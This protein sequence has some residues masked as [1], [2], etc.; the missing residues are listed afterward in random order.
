LTC[1]GT[2]VR[3]GPY[4]KAQAIIKYLLAYTPRPVSQ[5][6]LMDWLW[7]ESNL[8]R[9]R[10][11][12]GSTVYLLRR[13]LNSSLP[14]RE[15]TPDSIVFE[16]G[17]YSIH[18]A[19]RVS[20]DVQEFDVLYRHGRR[21]EEARRIREAITGYEMAIALCDGDYLAEDLHEGWTMV[22]RER[23]THEYI[24]A[25]DR[26]ADFQLETRE[27]RKCIESCYQLL[28][29]DPSHERSYCR[30]MHC[31]ASLG[32]R[33]RA[34]EQYRLCQ[35]V[36]RHTFGINPSSETQTL[37]R[38]IISNRAANTIPTSKSGSWLV[39]RDGPTYG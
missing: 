14:Q 17:Q 3:L 31:Y 19:I 37:Y 36:L 10:S 9:A 2:T 32:L 22:E 29:K 1:D 15:N 12:L 25:L 16:N 38:E 18:T 7:P 35:K 20:S 5:D 4:S 13:S 28:K 33:I 11:S 39:G 6:Y 23:L 34:L 8:K 26:L 24:D 27:L 21:L 30:M